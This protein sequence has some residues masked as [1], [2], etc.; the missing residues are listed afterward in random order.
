[1]A[2]GVWA[3]NQR[4]AARK[5]AENAARRAAGEEGV[6]YAGEL[7]EARQEA[8]AE[9]DPG[10]APA[11]D[12]SWQ[13]SYRLALAHVKAGGVFPTG[14]GELVVQGEDLGAWAGAQRVGWDRLMP[15]QQYLLETLGIEPAAEGEAVGPV[16]R[17]QEER[18][19]TNLA[20][21]RQFHAREG[22]LRPARKHVENV[23]GELIKLGAFLDNT[24]KRVG[25][26]S[27][28][29]R[30]QLAGFGLQW[31]AQEGSA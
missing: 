9:I 3:K 30:G 8:L 2:I 16:L 18:W 31:A 22:H 28:E 7:S 1:M 29:R 24:R 21:A 12:V 23:N 13:R 15:A 17:S 20:A 26:L 25:R 14:V 27:P 4:A 6:S 10:W 5:T 19:N 11:W